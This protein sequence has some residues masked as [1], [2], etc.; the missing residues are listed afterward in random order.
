M[1]DIRR[2]SGNRIAWI[3]AKLAI[4][5]AL[6]VWVFW[7]NVSNMALSGFKS[8]ES[9]HVL[10]V[11]IAILM[12]VYLRRSDWADCISPGSAWSVVL[13]ILTLALCAVFI[14]PFSYGYAYNIASV[15][16]LGSLVWITMGRRACKLSL[17]MLMLV[18]V[19]IPMGP[20][21]YAT[22]I[23]RPETY[24]IG[25]TAKTLDLLPGVDTVVKGVDIFFSSLRNSGVV[26]LGESNRGARLLLAFATIGIFVTF[27]Q[28]RSF[29][30]LLFVGITAGAVVLFCNFLRFM[31]WGL[32]TIY[33]SVSPTS[34]LPRNISAICSLF[35]VYAIF[36]LL[37]SAKVN[38][39]I[40]EQ[41]DQ[42][43]EAGNEA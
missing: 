9:A 32:A 1:H 38:L 10:T 16:V 7:H 36:V 23:I 20:R 27:S 21:L 31:V 37:C 41:E 28:A 19:A 25:A 39:F 12:L 18:M 14:W 42:S 40:E 5:S 17:P 11:P 35:A 3:T 13:L 43:R 33:L 24:T 6:Y 26:G 15:L 8:S 34:A 2:E 4:L 22:L 29:W 30:R